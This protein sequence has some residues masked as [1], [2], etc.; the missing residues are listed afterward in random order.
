MQE[1]RTS[2]AFLWYKRVS[3]FQA[4]LNFIV[5]GVRIGRLHTAGDFM[6][7]YAD[8]SDEGSHIK[9]QLLRYYKFA[10]AQG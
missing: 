10:H 3:G 5:Q 4:A 8:L 7:L 2:N 1:V 6:G 9:A